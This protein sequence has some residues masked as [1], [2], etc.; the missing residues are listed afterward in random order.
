MLEDVGEC[1]EAT[2]LGGDVPHILHGRSVL[3]APKDLWEPIMVV[4]LVAYFVGKGLGLLTERKTAICY[5][6][7][8]I[9]V[10]SCCTDMFVL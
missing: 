2:F 8:V 9:V 6:S 7:T 4:L 1:N 5:V 10:E 3:L